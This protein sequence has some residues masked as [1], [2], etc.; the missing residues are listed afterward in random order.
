[1]FT[2]STFYLLLTSLI[3]ST[4]IFAALSLDRIIIYFSPSEQVQDITVTNPD[5]DTLFLQTEVYLVSNPGRT[6]E[7]RVK[8]TDPDKMGLLATPSKA[9]IPTNSHK[10]LRL[11]SLEKPI[12]NEQVYRVTFKPI[13]GD[14]KASNTAIKLLI[15]Y[16]ALVFVR[17]NKPHYDVSAKQKNNQLTFT[18]SGNINAIMRNGQYCT[19]KKDDSCKP[20]TQ[21]TRLY[22]EQS[23]TLDIPL[24]STRIKYG[25]FDGDHEKTHTFSITS[26]TQPAEPENLKKDRKRQRPAG[27]SG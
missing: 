12:K 25:L 10:T 18:N 19:S 21:T 7:K 17:P 24:G 15:A 5:K 6:N 2:R 1:M 22:A 8:I 16:Q 14:L 20:L 9:V 4:N 11:I 27:R 23:W 13:V 3:F 26:P